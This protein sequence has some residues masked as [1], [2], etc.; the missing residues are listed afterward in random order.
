MDALI[1][2]ISSA[3]PD[4]SSTVSPAMQT[5]PIP[6]SLVPGDSDAREAVRCTSC[7]RAAPTD[8][9]GRGTAEAQPEAP[10]VRPRLFLECRSAEE[11]A[12]AASLSSL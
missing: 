1:P 7:R 6:R 10:D 4:D 12:R 5:H 9:P 3:G 8:A 2:K 11:M